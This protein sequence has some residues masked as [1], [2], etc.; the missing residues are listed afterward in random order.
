MYRERRV[1]KLT[2]GRGASTT[3]RA[4]PACDAAPSRAPPPGAFAWVAGAAHRMLPHSGLAP[5]TAR[6]SPKTIR[7]AGLLWCVWWWWWA[8]CVCVCACVCVCVCVRAC[9]CVC[10]CGYPPEPLFFSLV[11]MRPTATTAVP[12]T[13]AM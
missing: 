5:R 8:L 10:V 13:A 11:Y 1:G 4:Q 3:P 2:T 6:R 12:M 7:T 9:V